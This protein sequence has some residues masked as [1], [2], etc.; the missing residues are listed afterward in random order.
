M[1][2]VLPLLLGLLLVGCASPV[3]DG[4]DF[5]RLVR[6]RGSGEL[7]YCGT[8]EGFHYLTLEQSYEFNFSKR[9]TN[10][11]RLPVSEFL[12]KNTFAKT[13]HRSKWTPMLMSQYD[14]TQA[15]RGVNEPRL[16]PPF[17]Y[18]SSSI[19]HPD[20]LDQQKWPSALTNGNLTY[21]RVIE[22]R[23]DDQTFLAEPTSFEAARASGKRYN[24]YYL[25]NFTHLLVDSEHKLTNSSQAFF[26][27]DFEWLPDGRLCKKSFHYGDG[28]KEYHW[29]DTNGRPV[30]SI[31]EEYQSNSSAMRCY[32]TQGEIAL[33][34]L[35]K[36]DP[37]SPYKGEDK[38]YIGN[39]KVIS[40]E[41]IKIFR[42]YR[43]EDIV[44]NKKR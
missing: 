14:G 11:Y 23:R 39:R 12:I 24:A 41:F 36:D 25:L 13:S 31:Y 15:F 34:S 37:D 22:W 27:P 17:R 44:G 9:Y 29:L 21:Q 30:K 32:D 10:Y 3:L 18:N 1:T 33:R 6:E 4:M 5:Q 2:K 7:Y 42:E 40:D 19:H 35:S 28:I 43:R 38:Y 8:K 26:G 16:P 20:W